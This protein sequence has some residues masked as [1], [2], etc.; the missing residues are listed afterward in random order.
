MKDTTKKKNNRKQGPLSWMSSKLKVQTTK[1]YGK[2]IFAKKN[3][4]KDEIVSVLGGHV[5]EAF[6]EQKMLEKLS[7]YSLQINENLVI[8]P[9]SAREID[10]SDYFNHSCSPNV[11]FNGQ[12]FLV[13]MRNIKKG[14]QIT[15]DYAM[16]ISKAKG[17][18]FYKMRCLCGSKNCRGYIT[19]NDWKKTE[20]QKKYAG[21]FQWYLQKKIAKNKK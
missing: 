14:E 18:R 2:G 5:F 1:G 8:G 7:D 6:K 10:D 13:A 4:K 3:I 9:M 11:G 21:Y 20:L 19:D 17:A 15:F 16:V 12:I